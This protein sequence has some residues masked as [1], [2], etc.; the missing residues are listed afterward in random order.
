VLASMFFSFVT[1][2]G[3][4]AIAHSGLFEVVSGSLLYVQHFQALAFL[5]LILVY[6]TLVP[7]ILSQIFH[8]S[9]FNFLGRALGWLYCVTVVLSPLVIVS[10][11]MNATVGGSFKKGNNMAKGKVSKN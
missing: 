8:C 10:E 2:I 9:A 4:A 7:F 11:I 3:F 5:L 6:L 1:T